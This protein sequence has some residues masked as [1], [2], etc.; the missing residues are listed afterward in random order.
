MRYISASIVIPVKGNFMRKGVVAIDKTG[1]IKGVYEETD[2]EVSDVK[3]EFYD[4]VLIPGFVNA[5]CHIELSHM[6]GKTKKGTGLPRFLADVMKQRAAKE[7]DI[8]AKIEAA[9]ETMYNNGIQAVGDHV[10]TELSAKI[11]TNSRIKYHT[12]VEVMAMAKE[13]IQVRVDKARDIEFYFDAN[14]ASITPHAPYSCS[15]ELFK[16]FR[17]LV[18]EDN[19]LSVHNQESD[20]ENKLYRYKQG[21]FL[22]FYKEMGLNAESF[23]AQARNSIQSYLAH[24]PKNNRL[25]LVHNTYMSLKDIDFIERLGRDVYFCVCPK[26]NLYIEGKLP[27]ILNFV[28]NQNRMVIGTDSLASNDTL[29]ILEELKVISSHFS[30]LDFLQI[31]PW[32]TINGAEVL[33]LADQLGSIEVGKTPG[34][35]LLE[36]MNNLRLTER[37]TLKRI[38]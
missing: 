3:K 24:L 4:G 36:G 37:V 12:F 18:S 7:K 10:N 31:L 19:I 34:L 28:P 1:M 15:K 9:D 14:H 8:L 33:G 26:S 6:L 16:A 38:A 30:Q 23:K 29:D 25:M 35:V 5:H 17:K 11:K 20:E 21:E 27:K 32:A 2:P 13:D 22:E